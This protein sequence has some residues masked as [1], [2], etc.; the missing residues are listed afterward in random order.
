MATSSHIV[1][2]G[3]CKVLEGLHDFLVAATALAGS[4]VGQK[5]SQSLVNFGRL[6]LG[7]ALENGL[8]EVHIHDKMQIFFEAPDLS[9]SSVGLGISIR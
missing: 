9:H 2:L 5:L 4:A 1:L 6:S 7:L 8:M 3:P